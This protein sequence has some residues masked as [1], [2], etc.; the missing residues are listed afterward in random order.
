AL[1]VYSTLTPYLLV[2]SAV[3]ILH[4]LALN[5]LYPKIVGARV[6]LNPLVVTIALMFWSV[7]WGPMG[8]ILA[9]PLTAA[10]KAICDNVSGLQPYG[11]LLGD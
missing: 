10:I 8:L 1:P 4:L 7:L 3:A 2:G 5:L 11:R 9:I 6:H